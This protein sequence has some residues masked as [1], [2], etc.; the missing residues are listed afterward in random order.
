MTELHFWMN[1]PLKKNNNCEMQHTY[2]STHYKHC[3][4]G[5]KPG[6][7]LLVVRLDPK[8]DH[9]TPAR[10]SRGEVCCEVLAPDLRYGSQ[11]MNFLHHW[12]TMNKPLYST[13]RNSTQITASFNKPRPEDLMTT[14]ER[15]REPLT[16]PCYDTR[17]LMTITCV[18]TSWTCTSGR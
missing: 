1:Y 15:C 7:N 10:E 3:L 12:R 8:N 4:S 17:A 5:I 11:P 9:T 2:R 13:S 14:D 6:S 16:G 18:V